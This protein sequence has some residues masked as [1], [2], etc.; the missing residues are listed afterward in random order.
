VHRRTGFDEKSKAI[1]AAKKN[2]RL[3]E[4]PPAAW[5]RSATA[6]KRILGGMLVQN[7]TWRN[8]ESEL[9]T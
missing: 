8:P 9:R 4:I 2:L 3:L 6:T 1:F 7:P 5:S